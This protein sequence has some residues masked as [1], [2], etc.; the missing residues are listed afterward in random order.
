MR[1]LLLREGRDGKG[2]G[3]EEKGWEGIGQGRRREGR[4]CL[5]G[6]VADEAFCLKSAPGSNQISYMA[7]KLD[8]T[9]ISA[10]ATMPPALTKN[11][12]EKNAD[13][14]AICLR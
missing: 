8:E 5:S 2:E 7:M 6:N 11:F 3:R 4:G 9:N 12:C 1:G 13:V 10:R 14:H